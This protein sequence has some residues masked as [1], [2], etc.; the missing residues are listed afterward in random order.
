MKS[1]ILTIFT[2]ILLLGLS[3]TPLQAQQLPDPGDWTFEIGIIPLGDQPIEFSHVRLRTFR[4]TDTAY[5]L[6][7]NFRLMSESLPN[8]ERETNIEFMVAPGIERHFY[9]DDR[10]S[11]YYGAEIGIRYASSNEELNAAFN[12]LAGVDVHF[13]DR[14]YSGI[15]IGYGLN[16][17]N[18]GDI[19]M[20]TLTFPAYRLGF[21]F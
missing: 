7:A 3:T 2:A 14:L 17:N 1:T 11:A 18:D 5:R 9:Q 16:F 10:I 6:G 12:A 13:L 8:D 15:E 20:G 4:S 19:Y 21:R